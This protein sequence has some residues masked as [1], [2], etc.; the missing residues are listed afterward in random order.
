MPL[1]LHVFCLK[2]ER[3]S[4]NF[5]LVVSWSH[6]HMFWPSFY[7]FVCYLWSLSSKDIIDDLTKPENHSNI[8]TC[9]VLNFSYQSLVP[10]FE[11]YFQILL[12]V[13]WLFVQVK[14]PFVHF[15]TNKNGG[16]CILIVDE[17]Y[18]E[19]ISDGVIFCEVCQVFRDMECDSC[20]QFFSQYYKNSCCR[21]NSRNR[22]M[23]KPF[24]KSL[25]IVLFFVI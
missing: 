12:D 19:L 6:S 4:K 11:L 5:L 2:V 7:S 20:N 9:G 25:R 22:S 3:D 10:L 8:K 14:V 15:C 21:R 17:K 24:N 23:S 13:S 18:I 16:K 1:F